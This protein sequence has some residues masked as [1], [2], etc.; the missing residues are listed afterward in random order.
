[1]ATCRQDALNNGLDELTVDKL[2]GKLE[3]SQKSSKDLIQELMEEQTQKNFM[4]RSNAVNKN[5][6]KRFIDNAKITGEKYKRPYRRYWNYFFDDKNSVGVRIGSRIQRRL[7]DIQ[8][9]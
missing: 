9:E 1:M 7:A 2:M 8:A 3:V 5:R 4:E 6:G